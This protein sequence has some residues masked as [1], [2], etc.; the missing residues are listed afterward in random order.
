QV[1]DVPDLTEAR[2][3]T[4]WDVA[5]SGDSLL[6][7]ALSPED[8]LR[9]HLVT[10]GSQNFMGIS[11]PD[12]DRLVETLSATFDEDE[13]NE[14]LREIQQV[15]HDQGLW[16]ASVMRVPAVVTN[17]EWRSYETP[18]A[19]LWVTADTAPSR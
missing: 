18:I 19:N 8:G 1:T 4:D 5:L 11:N 10:G 7:F 15:I 13:R 16:A 2:E 14:L 12:I 6:S 17:A 3:G 9:S